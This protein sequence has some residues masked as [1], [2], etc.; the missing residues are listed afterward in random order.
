MM[1]KNSYI[2]V[3]LAVLMF[4]FTANAGQGDTFPKDPVKDRS[5]KDIQNYETIL[6]EV[7]TILDHLAAEDEFEL[8]GTMGIWEVT[9][10]GDPSSIGYA[11]KDINADGSPE[12]I[13]AE[14]KEIKDNVC[15]G[16]TVYAVYTQVDGKIYCAL[17]GYNRN[18][19]Q[20]I[21]NDTFFNLGSAGATHTIFGTY[22]LYPHKKEIVCEDYYFTSEKDETDLT[23]LYYHNSSGVFDTAVSE[24]M[25]EDIFDKTLNYF[26]GQI[27][28]IEL[29]P[30][31]KNP[32]AKA[33]NAVPISVETTDY[34]EEII[35][36]GR[37]YIEFIADE[38][39]AQIKIPFFFSYAI[40][41][42]KVLK[43]EL[44]DIN[45]F[46]NP[47]F[48]T[49]ELYTCTDE[50]DPDIAFILGMTF[51]GSIPSYGISF[52]DYDGR[53][54]RFAIVENV[55]DEEDA[56]DGERVLPAILKEF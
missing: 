33:E 4:A 51:W 32:A 41:D 22:A 53:T 9:K 15:F 34:A 48:V 47:T 46:E 21:N 25:K 24:R 55:Q 16:S 23:I 27:K 37:P 44:E 52:T 39:D 29:V 35:E 5:G 1:K 19:Y 43:L 20:I 18:S 12:L 38:S 54:R 2:A 7:D 56:E 28:Q 42:L 3:L 36:D 8:E 14:I 26:L 13:I 31:S 45:E 30:F 40:R 10:Y 11:K 17:E 50:L 49:K 6:Q